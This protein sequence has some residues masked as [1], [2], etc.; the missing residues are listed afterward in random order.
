MEKIKWV[1]T[2]PCA[3]CTATPEITRRYPCIGCEKQHRKDA[4]FK[5]SIKRRLTNA[6]RL[7]RNSQIGELRENGFSYERIAIL[8]KMPRAT[9]QSA[10]LAYERQKCAS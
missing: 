9:V 10:A 3:K 6:D 1:T 7:L 2:P 5:A 8:L 4:T